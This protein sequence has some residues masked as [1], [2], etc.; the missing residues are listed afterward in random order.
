MELYG[1]LIQEVLLIRTERGLDGSWGFGMYKILVRR[2]RGV[3]G[4]ISTAGEETQKN[5][6]MTISIY[7]HDLV[8]IPDSWSPANLIPPHD[9]PVNRT[10]DP[11]R[12]DL[13]TDRVQDICRIKFMALV[14]KFLAVDR[15]SA[16]NEGIPTCHLP[17]P[18]SRSLL[19]ATY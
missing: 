19:C 12:Q 6:A 1:R 3:H 13:L 4:F 5:N 2:L 14:R 16:G 7:P 11:S 8:S 10:R 18:S 15:F 9:P 17:S